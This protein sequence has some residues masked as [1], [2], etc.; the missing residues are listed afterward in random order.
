M[1][2]YGECVVFVDVVHSGGIDQHT[3][4]DEEDAEQSEDK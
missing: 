3:A 2:E 4:G 1:R